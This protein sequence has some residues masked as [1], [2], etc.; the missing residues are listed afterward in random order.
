MKTHIMNSTILGKVSLLA[1]LAVLLAGSFA[2]ADE[3]QRWIPG[4]SGSISD[5]SVWENA[6][7]LP[8]G[9]TGYVYDGVQ[10]I[11]D[12]SLSGN[13]TL[14]FTGGTTSFTSNVN[15]SSGSGFTVKGGTLNTYQISASGATFNVSGGVWN[16]GAERISLNG[17]STIN[18]SGSGV[19]NSYGYYFLNGRD[20][21]GFTVQSGDSVL[22]LNSV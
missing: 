17:N 22:N 19:I 14:E 9:G 4:V 15:I 8:S 18:L 6:T 16:N 5:A 11:T 10:T 13:R 1:F 2:Q 7:A 3:T 12:T 21:K 20:S